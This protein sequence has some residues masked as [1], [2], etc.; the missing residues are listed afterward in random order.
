MVLH[1]PNQAMRY[2][3]RTLLLYGDGNWESGKSKDLLTRERLSRLYKH[4]IRILQQGEEKLFI[5]GS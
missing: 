4:P 2:C 3:D 5:P 1:D